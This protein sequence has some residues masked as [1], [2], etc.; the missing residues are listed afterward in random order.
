[1][2]VALQE[3]EGM[4]KSYAI[5]Y[6][7]QKPEELSYRDYDRIFRRQKGI[8]WT[9]FTTERC[10]VREFSMKDLD[11]LWDLYAQPSVTDYIQPLH[12]TKEKEEAYQR[13]YIHYMYG[14]FEYG[15][16]LVE[17]KKTGR[18]IGRAGIETNERC[19]DGEAELGYVIH[20]EN[21]RQGIATEVCRG[22]LQYAARELEIHSIFARVHKKNRASVGLL[23]K[24][25]FVREES[26]EDTIT[27]RIAIP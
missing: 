27:F 16:W 9:I 1:M 26:Q 21:Q 20:P 18:I 6:V 24:L 11:A 14:F 12:E 22:I 3:T 2:A 17:D 10:V 15:M 5:P 7:I 23:E 13:D 19:R 8:P 4:E 25:G